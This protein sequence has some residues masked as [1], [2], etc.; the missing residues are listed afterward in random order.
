M[1][2]CTDLRQAFVILIKG[3]FTWPPRFILLATILYYFDIG[4][5]VVLG[6][7]YLV[8]GDIWWG[9]L[10]LAFV[11]FPLLVAFAPGCAPTVNRSTKRLFG[12]PHNVGP[13]FA[14]VGLF[15]IA[16]QV[17]AAKMAANGVADLSRPKIHASLVFIIEMLSEAVPQLT[18]QLYIA[19]KTNSLDWL[20]I[21]SMGS[22]LLTISL[23]GVDHLM[24]FFRLH[25]HERPRLT[26]TWP[27]RA[28]ATVI[29]IVW[30]FLQVSTVAP[31]MA[32]RG[33]L[34]GLISSALNQG[35]FLLVTIAF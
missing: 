30:I 28:V 5:D 8:D 11:A 14:A 29:F 26:T 13:C 25:D 23:S 19:S 15:P 27:R 12:L 31:S 21:L 32:L 17:D 6:I 24:I 16:N 33:S 22:S 7:R 3:L 35:L 4:S 18:L 9:Q 34:G 1:G 2:F 20:E 10:T